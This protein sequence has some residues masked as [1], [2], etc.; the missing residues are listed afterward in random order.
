MTRPPV[1][2][3]DDY[4]EPGP[5]VDDD[6]G[7]VHPDDQWA[8]EEWPDDEAQE[9]APW[10]DWDDDDAD[11]ADS[12]EY[13][14]LRPPSSRGR[15]VLIVLGSMAVLFLLVAGGLLVWV[16]SGLPVKQLSRKRSSGIQG[17]RSSG[18][19]L[20]DLESEVG[21]VTLG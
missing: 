16:R 2:G 19:K 1:R 20:L 3:D 13:E 11:L 21:A 17:R 9:S 15:R 12:V 4:L 10:E 6:E 18:F 5:G 8:D 7:E 14:D